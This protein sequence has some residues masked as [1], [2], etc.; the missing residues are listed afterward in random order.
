MKQE[1]QDPLESSFLTPN[2]RWYA[3]PADN[4]NHKK[5][6]TGPC[7]RWGHST[8]I[9]D[10][11]LFIYG[12]TG[13][14]TNTRYWESIYQLDLENWDW[15][16]LEP[17]NK[18]PNSRDS[19]SCIVH[20]N[21]LY[22]FGGSGGSDSKNDMYEY[23]LAASTWKRLDVKGDVPSPREG[24]AACL[25]DEKYMVIYGGWNGEET[26]NNCYLFDIPQKT[27]I[28]V[29]RMLGQGPTPRE[30]QS[31]CMVRRDMYFFGG[32]GNNIMKD[33]ES[34]DNFYNDLYRLKIRFD[35]DRRLHASATWEL[36]EPKG[37]KPSKRSSH[38]SCAYK[39]RY[40]FIVG[41]EGYPPNIDEEK[42]P[43]EYR[44]VKMDEN[45]EEY[46]C[47]PKNDVWTY[48]VEINQWFRVKVKN[49]A[50]FI[51][52]FAHSNV[53]YKECLVV[54][55]GLHDYHNSTN[56]I[57]VL[58]LN[59]ENPFQPK[60]GKFSQYLG[61][62]GMKDEEENT[63]QSPSENNSQLQS[64]AE[65]REKETPKLIAPPV[66]VSVSLRP[67]NAIVVNPQP[68]Y[69]K[70]IDELPIVE[71]PIL[72]T[73]FLYSLSYTISWPLAA[74]GLL[75]DNAVIAGAKNL[76][77][78]YLTRQRKRNIKDII[79]DNKNKSS[80]MSYIVIEDNGTGWSPED[81]TKIM[82]SY[83]TD[84]TAAEVQETQAILANANAA[85]NNN[86]AIQTE[87]PEEEKTN[88]SIETEGAQLP[89]GQKSQVNEY[90]FNFK[91]GGV[92]LGRNIVFVSRNGDE[93]SL[94]FLT[95]D[96]RFNPNLHRHHTFY[97][98][99][100]RSTGEY[101][102]R[103]AEKNRSIIR[104]ALA[105]VFTPEELANG[106]EKFG[107]RIV[108]FDLS[109]VAG[110]NANHEKKEDLELLLVKKEQPAPVNDIMV[111][112]LDRSLK[113]FYN[114]PSSSLVELSLRTY[115]SHLFLNPGAN[116]LNI[117]LNGT[118]VELK[119]VKEATE[120]RIDQS[121]SVRIN[122]PNS[123]EGLVNKNKQGENKA[124]GPVRV[125]EMLGQGPLGQGVLI[126][127]KNRLIRR[128]ENSKMGN[129]DFLSSSFNSYL[130][131]RQ[132]SASQ[133]L[134]ERGGY[135]ELKDD[136]K[137]NVFKTE[138][139]NLFYS[140]YL[141]HRVMTQIH[142]PKSLNAKR[143]AVKEHLEEEVVEKRVKPEPEPAVIA[144]ASTQQIVPEPEVQTQ[145]E[146][147]PQPEVQ[148]QPEPQPEIQPEPQ[149]EVQVQ[150]EAQP[151]PESQPEAQPSVT[152]TQ[153]Q[154][155]PEGQPQAQTE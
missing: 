74:F 7:R 150:P 69:E 139:E 77:I 86:N 42:Q 60:P 23:D 138:M 155:Q 111:R 68:K 82:S 132:H 15:T 88:M 131:S 48:D 61:E 100:K 46:P 3:R 71:R 79:D 9:A 72:S 44:R 115:L 107:N 93:I 80:N 94:G 62:E 28:L 110:S 20:N 91:V 59:G 120:A 133:P 55:G 98:S 10:N 75:V 113:P 121:S 101:L 84:I 25:F 83:D 30:S 149:P 49:E 8:A 99:W 45:G 141:F 103:R 153:Q 105:G 89:T 21:K 134:F 34:L 122:E 128:L 11:R 37:V 24:H 43:V 39:D 146:P 90:G 6:K 125:G 108:I 14:T 154:Q 135:I 32:Q 136:F 137:P 87:K 151:Q 106:I 26:F 36:V 148:A 92:R 123:F 65:Y 63:Y 95:A 104:N 40:V 47:F 16:K 114:D 152:E 50:D 129:L 109:S 66:S 112:S 12:G 130:E 31:C 29:E 147:Q 19:H 2:A 73:S 85:A 145:P 54:F 140:N 67:E 13:Y 22:I 124:E 96:R 97:Y 117:A 58:C 53:I 76:S 116:G 56:D 70:T 4:K 102:T 64:E 35:D 119:N 118:P 17:V 33:G 57:H 18:A 142:E 81:F 51:P 5:N 27:W 127:Y 126:Y 78:N 143:P 41:G 52:R 38:S 1:S 144:P